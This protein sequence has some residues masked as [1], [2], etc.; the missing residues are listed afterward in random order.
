MTLKVGIFENTET[1]EFLVSA[2][3]FDDFATFDE[4]EARDEAEDMACQ[5]ESTG[6]TATVERT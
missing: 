3:G 2:P 6:S 1:G 5:I 4:T